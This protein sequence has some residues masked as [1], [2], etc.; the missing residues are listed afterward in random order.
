[1]RLLGWLSRWQGSGQ[2][3]GN[4]LERAT[5][6]RTAAPRA[7]RRP[8]GFEQLESRIV[9]ADDFGDAPDTGAGTGAGNYE[10]LLA[11]NGPRHTIVA[12]L[13]LGAT[14]DGEADAT[15]NARANG[16]DVAADPDDE[17]GVVNPQA[18]FLL[19]TGTQPTITLLVTNTTGTAATLSGW[20]DTNNNGL[21]ETTERAQVAVPA[22]TNNG[23][24]TLTFPVVCKM[25]AELHDGKLLLTSKL[26]EGTTVKMI[27]P[28]QRTL[29]SRKE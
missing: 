23:T 11:N 24:F 10:T 17:D 8:L 22:G 27:F 5:A 2:R 19:T 16:D 3:S 28:H 4:R 14:V 9:L 13:R 1:M 7:K 29:L 6:C 18:D 26:G 25:Y 15:P 12:G 20:I 21:F